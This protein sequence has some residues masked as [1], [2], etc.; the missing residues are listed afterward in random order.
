MGAAK[1]IEQAIIGPQEGPQ[2]MFL[3]TPA[4]IAIYG[5]AAGGGKSWALEFEA[6]RHAGVKGFT[7]AIFRK[8]ATQV[9]NPGGLWDESMNIYPP[10]GG[11]SRSDRLEWN[12]PSGASVR[13]AHLE[14]ENT[15]LNWQGAQVCYIGFDELTHFSSYQFFY[16][17]SRNRSTCGIRPYIRATC[18]PDADSWVANF[19]EWWID[20]ATGFAIPER[21]GALRWMARIDDK[22]HWADSAEELIAEHGKECMPKSVTFIAAN[23]SDNKILMQAD[24]GYL[25]GLRAMPFV[26]RE[27]LLGGNW[28]I[29]PAAGLYFQRSWC[30]AVDAAPADM[31]TVR[32]WDLA[33]TEKT[34]HNDPDFTACI[35]MGR[36]ADGRIYVTHGVSMR[37]SPLHVQGAIKNTAEQDGRTVVVGLPQDPGQAGKS[38]AHDFARMLAG[39]SVKIRP[40]SGSKVTRFGGFSAQCEAGNVF[41]VRGPWNEEFFD[42]LEGFP[43][44]AHDDHADACSG[45]FNMLMEIKPAASFGNA[46]TR[47]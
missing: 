36:T 23:L 46:S 31:R 19:I 16:M 18:N 47:A 13:F 32:Y 44:A 10:L 11:R 43:D 38:Q 7:A 26:D 1:K 15:V 28:K 42:Q 34:S 37:K 29:R 9:L 25:A 17:F 8:N 33:A 40:E 21:S 39:F 20:Q 6:V 3:S 41:F 5:G 22:I 35:K 45:A 24:P 2:E 30:Q 14:H 27:R 4:D 12:F